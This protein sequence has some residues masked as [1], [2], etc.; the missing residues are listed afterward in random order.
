M[1]YRFLWVEFQLDAICAEASDSGIEKALERVP[2]DMDATYERILKTINEKPRPK[3]KVA[4]RVLLWTAYARRPL[5][6][7]ELACAISVE[8]DTKDL[9]DLTSSNPAE[10]YIVD[11][12]ANLV[13][14]E[15]AG[16]R[17]VRFVH[18]SVQEFLTSHRST[19]LNMEHDVAH[20]EIAQ[21]CM[22]FLTLCPKPSGHYYGVS[23]EL[24]QYAL[25]E[26]P[27]HLLAGNLNSLPVSDHMVTFTL[28]FL[29]RIPGLLIEQPR[30]LGRQWNK[31]IYLKFS[32]A[33]LALI[34][35]LPP[36][37][38]EL[39]KDQ[40]MV[41][42]S[43][44]HDHVIIPDDKLAVHYAT[45]ELD[46]VTVLRR[47]Y[48][49]RY[50]LNYS[51]S[52]PEGNTSKVPDCL[53]LSSLYLVRST[54]VAKYLLDSG[55]SICPQCLED[56]VVD[57]LVY[58]AK[59]KGLVWVFQLV[60]ERVVDTCGGRLSRAMQA[61]YQ[62]N[63]LEAIRLLLDKGC[64]IDISTEF[65]NV[66]QAAA[67]HSDVGVIRLLLD[68]EV[69][70]NTQGG[71]YGNALQAAACSGNVEVVQL[72]LDNGANVN[73]QGGE[74][75]DALQ[76]A[77][78]HDRSEAVRLLL[79]KGADVNAQGG[80]YGNALQAAVSR[81]RMEFAQLL[82]DKGANVN[83]HGG[84]YGNTLQAA[85]FHS[86]ITDVRL[87]LDKG[88]DVNAQGGWYGNVLQ[89]AVSSDRIEV[90]QLLLD[91]GANVNAQ[92]GEYGNALKAAV[93]NS[94]IEVVQLL[95]D[96]GADVNAQDGKYGNV[97]QA[98]VSRDRT[99]VV[100]LL[101]DKGADVNAQGGKYGNVLQAA[102]SRDRTEVAQL[103]L[104][105]GAVI[106]AQGGEYGDVFQ[107]EVSYD[108]TAAV[109]LLDKGAVNAQ[110]RRYGNSLQA[111]AHGRTEVVRLLLD[112]GADVNAQGGRYGNA[113][114]AAAYCG[115]VE[116]AQLLL[117]RGADVN[118]QGGIFGT[119][120]QAAAYSGNTK[121][122]QLLLDSGAH[123]NARGGK[124]GA[125]LKK[126]LSLEPAG[127]DQKVPG[128]IPLLVELL[129]EHAPVSTKQ[130]PE[131]EYGR[132]ARI[133]VNKKRC[134]L[135]VF[136]ELLEERG[137]KRG[138]KEERPGRLEPLE[139]RELYESE[140]GGEGGVKNGIEDK[141]GDGGEPGNEISQDKSLGTLNQSGQEE[142]VI[143]DAIEYGNGAGTETSQELQH[144]SAEASLVAAEA[145]DMSSQQEDVIGG[146]IEYGDGA[147]NETSQELQ[148]DSPEASYMSREEGVI[149]GETG[150]GDK[151]ASLEGPNKSSL[152]VVVHVWKLLGFT[153]LV[154]LLYTSF[155][156]FWGV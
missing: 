96:K 137:W 63:C 13:S 133:M 145:P 71:L 74:Y 15:R 94:R 38:I 17:M 105:E 138:S 61:A 129:Q 29:E 100:Q 121:V 91:K 154:F 86:T 27:H 31:K 114:Q 117:D 26:W 9:E 149:G 50:S 5:S 98:A 11:A 109:R 18:F 66:L 69:D 21:A 70:V 45:A 146:E 123:I 124:Y 28:S 19:T 81:G 30:W 103:L 112:K 131:L 54:E 20:R 51:Y 47:L 4:R 57:P 16:R 115:N 119:V 77:V 56:E 99:E 90:V 75:G 106:N 113:L 156:E 151:D 49:Y 150:H 65:S 108:R 40:S 153:F 34:F 67:F 78:S 120:L 128:D 87:L 53:Q 110:G 7:D 79:D 72:L 25:K 3:R 118:L 82:L 43:H 148:P 42:H 59:I 55:I 80:R 142:D 101:L 132:L 89:A 35:H 46:S 84:E 92:G 1:V 147:G 41:V 97:L 60:L 95:L 76:A 32:P 139:K 22:I 52:D 85:A 44:D 33:V 134:G 116:V 130:S 8:I 143:E 39:E 93:F 152:K 73:A 104:D 144:D 68:K 37:P 10:D 107:A 141:V 155:I 23:Q 58:F 102:V 136:R 12:C 48:S 140:G 135:D 88:A 126:M 122:I 2:D 125:I 6:I 127:T 36:L 62:A 83:A 14:I 24:Y 64:G 111:V